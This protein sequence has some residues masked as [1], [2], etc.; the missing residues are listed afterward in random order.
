[1]IEMWRKKRYNNRKVVLA[2]ISKPLFS[3]DLPEAGRGGTDR[4]R[5]FPQNGRYLR[6][7]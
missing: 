7:Q 1:M 4:G 5:R 6:K 3:P 2:E